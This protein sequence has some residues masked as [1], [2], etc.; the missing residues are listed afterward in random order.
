M[1]DM[2]KSLNNTRVYGGISAHALP[3]CLL[4]KE[5]ELKIKYNL[6]LSFH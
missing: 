1:N 4:C 6:N 2:Y 5:R 3:R